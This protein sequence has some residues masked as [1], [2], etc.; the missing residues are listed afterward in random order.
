MKL[1]GSDWRRRRQVP[2]GAIITSATLQVNCTN[3]GN[4][5]R[6]YRL[7]QAGSKIEA[8]WNAARDRRGRGASPA[9]TAP[10]RTP[11]SP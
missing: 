9:P 10:P 3:A 8:T 7:T 4:A 11:A 6:L 1:P 5:M 2:A